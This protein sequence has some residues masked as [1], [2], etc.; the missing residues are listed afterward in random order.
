[1]DPKGFLRWLLRKGPAQGHDGNEVSMPWGRCF[2][3]SIPLY[4]NH[5]YWCLHLVNDP[6]NLRCPL[7]EQEAH[8]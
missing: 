6:E 3:T 2:A 1:M 8:S 5:W 7:W 4:K